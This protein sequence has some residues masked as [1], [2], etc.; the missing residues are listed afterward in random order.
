MTRLLFPF[1]DSFSHSLF[2]STQVFLPGEIEKVVRQWQALL[3]D[4]HACDPNYPGGRDLFPAPSAERRVTS[5]A[6]APPPLPPPPAVNWTE[7]VQ[8]LVETIKHEY[9]RA[10]ERSNPVYRPHVPDRK[11]IEKVFKCVRE[12]SHFLHERGI[13]SLY[14][15]Y[16][17][18]LFETPGGIN[19]PADLAF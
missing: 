7:E 11:S 12:C 5:L 16:N 1:F 9:Q 6:Q 17:I 14:T 2:G 8:T 19:T 3:K 18:C 15:C 4:A 10:L 13:K